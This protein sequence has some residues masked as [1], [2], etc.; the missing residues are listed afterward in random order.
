MN[1]LLLNYIQ[2]NSFYIM[3]IVNEINF[4]ISVLFIYYCMKLEVKMAP[5]NLL[6]GL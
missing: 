6:K 3:I 1:S 5:K 4:T 2:N